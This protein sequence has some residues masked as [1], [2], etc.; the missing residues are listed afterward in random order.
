M[1]ARTSRPRGQPGS[2]LER[3]WRR[4][5][6]AHRKRL[7]ARPLFMFLF[8][9]GQRSSGRRNSVF[10]AALSLKKKNLFFVPPTPAHD[11]EWSAGIA[12]RL[13][14]YSRAH[15][16]TGGMLAGKEECSLLSS[17]RHSNPLDWVSVEEAKIPMMTGRSAV[18]FWKYWESQSLN[19]HDSLSICCS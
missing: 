19:S 5:E 18:K 14:V 11:D 4:K 15:L 2:S 6:A 17:A 1:A 9:T 13:K 7:C 3:G 16:K 8:T 12:C 10:V